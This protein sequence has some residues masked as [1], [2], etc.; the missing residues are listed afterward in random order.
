[1]EPQKS[2][3]KLAETLLD[4]TGEFHVG[5]LLTGYKCGGLPRKEGENLCIRKARVPLKRGGYTNYREKKGGS[6][7]GK[8]FN[9]R[10]GGRCTSLS[11]RSEKEKGC[12]G[13]EDPQ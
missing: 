2:E 1:M 6:K 4:F 9:P 8:G 3:L 13:I 5:G 11:K 12:G 10:K 7:R